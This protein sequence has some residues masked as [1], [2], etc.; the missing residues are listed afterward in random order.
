MHIVIGL[1]SFD[2]LFSRNAPLSGRELE[3]SVRGVGSSPVHNLPAIAHE[4]TAL[5]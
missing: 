5:W 3:V 4:P 2:F 1:H